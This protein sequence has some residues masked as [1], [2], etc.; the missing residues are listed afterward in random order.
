MTFRDDSLGCLFCVFFGA[1]FIW[2]ANAL[3]WWL[4]QFFSGL[5][6]GMGG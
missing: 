6:M 4:G 5:A 2:A 3:L 1:L